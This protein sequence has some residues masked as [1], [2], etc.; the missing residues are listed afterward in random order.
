MSDG[1]DSARPTTPDPVDYSDFLFLRGQAQ[2]FLMDVLRDSG[3]ELTSELDPVEFE[4][5]VQIELNSVH[6]YP[7]YRTAMQIELATLKEIESL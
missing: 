6:E 4:R 1:L 5:V 3:A 2:Q 7:D